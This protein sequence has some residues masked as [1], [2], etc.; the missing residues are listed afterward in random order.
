ME[1]IQ[2]STWHLDGLGVGRFAL[3]FDDN[4]QWGPTWGP[5]LPFQTPPVYH[6]KW[7]YTLQPKKRY[8]IFLL[9]DI[10]YVMCIYICIYIYTYI[11]I[12]IHT[13]KCVCIYIYTHIY[14]YIYIQNVPD[15]VLRFQ[16]KVRS[17]CLT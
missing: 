2:P 4:D 5:A 1:D 9:D 15:F 13:Q 14:I 11:Y 12:H 7:G 10:L 6:H 17:G 16:D 3:S 8:I